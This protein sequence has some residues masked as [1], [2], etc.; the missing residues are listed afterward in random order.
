M[1]ALSVTRVNAAVEA[2]LEETLAQDAKSYACN[3]STPLRLQYL[4]EDAVLATS[5]RTDPP[6]DA[7]TLE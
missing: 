7:R 4:L 2:A 3:G 1:L 6:P 5:C